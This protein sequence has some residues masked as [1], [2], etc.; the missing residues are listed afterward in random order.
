MLSEL[1]PNVVLLLLQIVLARQ[2]EICRIDKDKDFDQL[3]IEPIL[4]NKI[5]YQFT[6]HALT[7][8]YS[9]QVKS[10]TIRKLKTLLA[11]IFENRFKSA[12]EYSDALTERFQKEEAT[13]VTL[14][15]FYY[16]WRVMQ[17]EQNLIPTARDDIINLIQ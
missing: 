13:V 10:L 12:A 1:P 16:N 15:N 17:L 11:E 14:A 9:P 6:T 8:L 3:I 4:D 7:Q 5:L 2:Q